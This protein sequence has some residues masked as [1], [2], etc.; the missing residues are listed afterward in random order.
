MI[1]RPTVQ[2]TIAARFSVVH[3]HPAS[4]LIRSNT[5]GLFAHNHKSEIRMRCYLRLD[6]DALVLN[7]MN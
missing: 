7:I 3:S 2:S 1:I 5:I 6:I 4:I